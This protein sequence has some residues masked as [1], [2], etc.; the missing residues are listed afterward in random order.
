MVG[1]SLIYTDN[2]VSEKEAIFLKWLDVP[3]GRLCQQSYTGVKDPCD[4]TSE[5]VIWK[6]FGPEA[7][8]GFPNHKHGT[9]HT[10]EA[11][12]VISVFEIVVPHLEIKVAA[13][14]T[15]HPPP[16]KQHADVARKEQFN[17]I[18]GADFPN[19]V[20]AR[21]LACCSTVGIAGVKIVKNQLQPLEKGVPRPTT[22]WLLQSPKRG[23]Q[24][25]PGYPNS[26]NPKRARH[27]QGGLVSLS[28]HLLTTAT[29][30]GGQAVP[31]EKK[32]LLHLGEGR[33]GRWDV[34]LFRSRSNTQQSVCMNS[35]CP[36]G[37][38]HTNTHTLINWKQ[39]SGV[40]LEF[41]SLPADPILPPQIYIYKLHAWGANICLWLLRH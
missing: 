11:I 8:F 27:H 31:E 1:E 33:R 41:F 24:T 36:F 30:V 17:P 14:A 39:A 35:V 6:H 19:I 18:L 40:W 20:K 4:S 10:A 28:F 5:T 34:T 21:F 2:S 25:E 26:G 12:A 13:L 3:E 23:N 32:I 16:T 9:N 15:K 29:L 38:F 22:H 7:A 37:Q